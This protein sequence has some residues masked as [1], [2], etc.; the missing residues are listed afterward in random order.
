MFCTNWLHTCSKIRRMYSPAL[1]HAFSEPRLAR[2]SGG[3]FGAFGQPPMSVPMRC[4]DLTVTGA[5][6]DEC[7]YTTRT[8]TI[9]IRYKGISSDSF[10]GI[11]CLILILMS[12]DNL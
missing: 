6:S 8:K 11:H 5:K 1:G 3:G 9:Y 12:I 10:I 2:L 7:I 4:P